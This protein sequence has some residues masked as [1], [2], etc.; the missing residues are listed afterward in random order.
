VTLWS[1]RFRDPLDPA[2]ARWQR[3]LPFDRRLLAYELRAG[4][5]YASALERASILTSP[6]AAAL[7]S[8]L[9]EIAASAAADPAF[10]DDPACEDVHEFV[11]SRLVARAGDL[12]RKLHTGRSRNEQIATSLRL[13]V[14]DELDAIAGL[15]LRLVSQFADRAAQVGDAPMPGYTHL[16]G[17]E[18][19]LVAHWLLAYAEMFLRDAGRLADGRVR[20]GLCPLG[21][22]AIAGSTVA[23]DRA[24]LAR[25]LGFAAPTSNSIDATSDR[26]FVLEFVM[27]L[28]QVGLHL[29]R[30]AEEIVLFST[31]EFG[32]L[33]L[34]EPLSTGSSA[35]PQ[36][37]NPD[38]AELVRAK[39]GRL[40][41]DATA[42]AAIMKGLPLAYSKDM[43]ETQL[44]LFD[45]ADTVRETLPHV[46]SF[47][48][49]VR[50]DLDRLKE[51]AAGG[52]LEAFAAA[53]YLA[54]KGVPFRTA[55]EQ[56]GQAVRWAMEQ[57][58]SLRDL[59]LDQWQRFAPAAGP[60]IG[61]ALSLEAVLA[62]HDVPGGT[63]PARVREA[64]AAVRGRVAA[65]EEAFRARP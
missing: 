5:A 34:P 61:A 58:R 45:A 42:L 53:T 25:D 57:R 8:A 36:K 4:H 40:I 23:L 39:A 62:A 2:F 19:V 44:P 30:W 51:A 21:S 22:G 56:V 64:I 43:Q 15:L 52:H 16:Q 33:H 59:P 50:F 48:G 41:G 60:E 46:L 65:M 9:D 54:K 55:H 28:A 47:M 7:R 26:D 32:F 37:Q 38:L 29:S 63:H 24:A 35:M 6:E 13:Y 1:G 18:P 10:L 31:R 49:S 17:A 14:R 3:S 12:G 27:G 11:E 20:V